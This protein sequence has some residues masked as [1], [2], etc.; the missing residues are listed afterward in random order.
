MFLLPKPDVSATNIALPN[1]L[2]ASSPD[3]YLRAARLDS[4]N[5]E[6][7]DLASGQALHTIRNAHT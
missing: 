2:Q 4:V 5:I 7:S 3:G 6:V 1:P